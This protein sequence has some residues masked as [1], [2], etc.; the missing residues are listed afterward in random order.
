MKHSDRQSVAV[1]G[2]V[3]QVAPDGLPFQ[4]S[5]K[6]HCWRCDQPRRIE[7]ECGYMDYRGRQVDRYRKEGSSG[8]GVVGDIVNMMVCEREGDAG[9]GNP[10]WV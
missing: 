1:L 9:L 5:G 3:D 2:Q 6:R 7:G 8:S 4:Y 10:W